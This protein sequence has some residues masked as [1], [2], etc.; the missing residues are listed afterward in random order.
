M[1]CFA[2]PPGGCVAVRTGG[3]RPLGRLFMTV[4]LAVSLAASGAS[5]ARAADLQA[6]PSNFGSV[7]SSARGGDTI[8]LASGNYGTFSGGSK[9][10]TVTIT[11]ASG[12]SASMALTFSGANHIRLDGVTI[13]WLTFTGS[14]HDVTVANA[15]FQGAAVIRSD[16]MSNA[17]I[18]FDHVSV[19]NV[20][21]CSTCYEG[22]IEV[23]GDSGQPVGVTIKNSTLGPGGNADGVQIGGA[24]GVQLLNNEFTGIRQG[25]SGPHSDALQLM[26]STSTNVHGNYFHGNSTAIMAPDGGTTEQI[27]DNVFV[28]T[29]SEEHTS[30]LQSPQ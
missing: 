27:T 12:A 20:D 9:S 8:H 17:N 22:R 7:F 1:P 14:T 25:S 13:Q 21:V 29:R 23:M 30:E 24:R 15:T 19:P 5:A 28:G 6:T 10:S 3:R 2:A 11:P 4:A 26:G 18:V 16:Q